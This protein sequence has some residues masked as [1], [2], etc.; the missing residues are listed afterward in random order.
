MNAESTWLPT[1]NYLEKHITGSKFKLYP[2]ARNE[3]EEAIKN[4]RVD[5]FITNSIQSVYLAGKYEMSWVATK[6]S[7][8]AGGSL[9]ASGASVIVAA[10]SSYQTIHDLK[11]KRISIPS[12]SEQ[13]AGGHSIFRAKLKSLGIDVKSYFRAVV[14]PNYPTD[15]HLLWVRDG[16]VDAAVVPACLLEQL[17]QEKLVAP[18]ELRVLGKQFLQDFPCAS[19]T[20][21][22][23]NWNVLAGNWVSSE[24]SENV[25]YHLLR[26]PSVSE[27]AIASNAEG[28][29][30][31]PSILSVEKLL[32]ELNIHP[33]KQRWWVGAKAWFFERVELAVTVL[34]LLLVFAIYTVVR[35][36]LIRT[37]HSSLIKAEQQLA[38]KSAQLA[39]A[40]RVY[41]VG[42][43]G[44]SLAHEINQPL[45][46]ILNYSFIGKLRSSQD[47][48]DSRDFAGL[49]TDIHDQAER[50]SNVV[51]RIREQ[52][53]TSKSNSKLTD[54]DKLTSETLQLVKQEAVINGVAL[55]YSQLDRP[56]FVDMDPVAI[57]QVLIN[58]ITNAIE[59]CVTNDGKAIEKRVVVK[60]KLKDNNVYMNVIDTGI[61]LSDNFEHISKPFVTTK[62]EGLGLGLVICKDVIE[63]HGGELSLKNGPV[64]GCTAEFYLPISEE[65]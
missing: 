39:H 54:I 26:M 27:A 65:S 25:A 2:I 5:F 53:K 61:G 8:Y 14:S 59:A 10:E 35:E 23:P 46:S 50:A 56:C 11:G 64:V 24:L 63:A 37:K 6:R 33:L 45:T 32:L 60:T 51:K 1:L 19:S 22:F 31:P 7:R 13:T 12:L 15:M 55:S 47:N 41:V 38:D 4:Q 58:L 34:T 40:Q 3:V 52:V 57:Q 49:F 48:V 44:S 62:T 21:L 17:E 16:Y 28:W 20:K 43:L 42:E 36:R 30:V 9:V 18:G 29:S